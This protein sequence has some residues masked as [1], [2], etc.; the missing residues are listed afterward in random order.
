MIECNHNF[1]MSTPPYIFFWLVENKNGKPFKYGFLSNWYL[2]PIVYEGIKYSCS[3]QLYMAFKAKHFGD[4]ESYQKILATPNPRLAKKLGQNVQNF[5]IKEWDRVKEEYMYIACF[6]KFK[7][8]PDL[9]KK[10]LST[11]NSILVEASPY[12]KVWGIGMYGSVAA[13]DETRWQ[14]Q[15]LLGKCLEKVRESLWKGVLSVPLRIK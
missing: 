6:E 8:N 2:A 4:N 13:T 9:T 3:E 5:D 10:L 15:N 7:Q 11:C 14:G 1:E 12:D